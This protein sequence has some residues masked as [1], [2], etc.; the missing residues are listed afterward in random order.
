MKVKEIIEI[1]KKEDP[2]MEVYWEDTIGGNDCPVESV[3]ITPMN[4]E[5]DHNEY[6][7][8]ENPVLVAF[9][10]PRKDLESKRF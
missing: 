4:M 8:G 3:Y 2:E 1:L 6:D 7:L 5:S 10:S 9:I